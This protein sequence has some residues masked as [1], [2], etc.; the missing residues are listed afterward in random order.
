[1]RT[2]KSGPFLRLQPG[3]SRPWRIWLTRLCSGATI[4]GDT[5]LNHWSNTGAIPR[6]RNGW[7]GSQ[8]CTVIDGKKTGRQVSDFRWMAVI[9]SKKNK[10]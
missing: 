9:K 10:P 8:A 3:P 5:L 6:L 4:T 2:S 7:V 1:M